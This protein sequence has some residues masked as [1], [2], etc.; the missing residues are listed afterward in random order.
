MHQNVFCRFLPP[1]ALY[2]LNGCDLFNM[3]LLP[4]PTYLMYGHLSNSKNLND[5]KYLRQLYDNI[6]IQV[7][8]LTSLGMD[9]D[10]YGP[11]L[12]PVVISK[13]AKNFKLTITQ[14]FGEN[15]SDIKSILEPF[16]NELAVQS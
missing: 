4:P 9:T 3:S 6:D 10:S 11:M 13:L 14:Q 5:F 15:L 8:N 16:K 12:I 2:L 7:H 1:F